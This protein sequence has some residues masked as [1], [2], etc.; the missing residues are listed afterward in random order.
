MESFNTAEQHDQYVDWLRRHWEDG[1]VL[2]SNSPPYGKLKLHVAMC[3]CIGGGGAMPPN[4]ET[5]TNYP[6]WCS[7]D[8]ADLIAIATDLGADRRELPCEICHP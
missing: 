6:K 8:R 2:H 7:D 4:G 5:W 1:Y 3:H